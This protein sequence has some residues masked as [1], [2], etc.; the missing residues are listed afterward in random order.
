[1]NGRR[2]CPCCGYVQPRGMVAPQSDGTCQTCNN[3]P[4]PRP[5]K[6]E[7]TPDEVEE[8]VRAVRVRGFARD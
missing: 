4:R 6:R 2:S 7:L 5:T 3:R 8:I 1:M